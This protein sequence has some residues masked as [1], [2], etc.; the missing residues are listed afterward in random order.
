MKGRQLLLYHSDF[1]AAVPAARTSGIDFSGG[2][3][4]DHWLFDSEGN[5]DIGGGKLWHYLSAAGRT[6]LPAGEDFA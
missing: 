3:A 5:T 1:E 4:I 2:S 6:F